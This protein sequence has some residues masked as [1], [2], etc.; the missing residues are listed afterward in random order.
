[1]TLCPCGSGRAYEECCEP[2]IEGREAA[3][4][5]EALMRSRYTA[6]ALRKFDYLNETVHPDLRDENDHAEMQQWS[7]AVEWTRG[8][9]S[10]PPK[11]GTKTTKREKFPSKPA[12]LSKACRNP[13][14]KMPFSGVKTAAGT[15]LT[16]RCTV[17]SLIVANLPRSDAMIPVPVE[18]AK[19]T[20][21]AAAKISRSL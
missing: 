21:N 12:M 1:M 4:T 2:Y 18:A 19:N 16:E 14:G 9:K 6:H 15:I 10:F 11:K 17:R 5:A 13:C 20:R 8:L 7:E 3:P